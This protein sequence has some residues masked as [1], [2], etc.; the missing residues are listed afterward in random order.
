MGG[1]AARTP[2]GAGLGPTTFV[3]QRVQVTDSPYKDVNRNPTPDSRT[4]GSGDA[5]VLRDGRV[6]DGRWSRP[7]PADPTTYTI[8]GRPAVLAAGQLWIALVGTSRSVSV[9]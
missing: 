2:D 1:R 4:V 9:R 6:Y 7:S 3:V 5:L 8:G